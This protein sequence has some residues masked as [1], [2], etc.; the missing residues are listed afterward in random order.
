VI[1]AGM[2]IQDPNLKLVGQ[3]LTIEPYGAGIKEGDKQFQRITKWGW[4]K[5]KKS[6]A[7]GRSMPSRRG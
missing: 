2:I 5:I 4:R 1:L 6:M 3:A 7:T